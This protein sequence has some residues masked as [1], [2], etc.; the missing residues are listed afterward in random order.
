MP[1]ISIISL[2][3]FSNNRIICLY[4]FI[5]K[6]GNESLVRMVTVLRKIENQLKPSCYTQWYSFSGPHYHH[7]DIC[8]TPSFMDEESQISWSDFIQIFILFLYNENIGRTCTMKW[9]VE[10]KLVL[11]FFFNES[12]QRS[13]RLLLSH[14]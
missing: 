14:N 12:Y 7:K 13:S 9:L 8:F 3:I 6:V 10:P 4:Q 5:A 1:F 2:L 11:F